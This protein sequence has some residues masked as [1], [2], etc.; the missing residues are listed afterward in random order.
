MSHQTNSAKDAGRRAGMRNGNTSSC[1]YRDSLSATSW[2]AGYLEGH[3]Q[4]N[5][6]YRHEAM[7]YHNDR[8]RMEFLWG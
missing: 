2:M 4:R 7:V 5:L 6:V 1:P 3:E 8:A